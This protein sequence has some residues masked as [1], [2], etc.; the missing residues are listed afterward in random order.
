M[1][2]LKALDQIDHSLLFVLTI[3]FGGTWEL[4]LVSYLDKHY[5]IITTN[6]FLFEIVNVPSGVP[7]E[8]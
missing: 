8:S 7:R 5:Q 6:D 4:N 2:F 3:T 1:D